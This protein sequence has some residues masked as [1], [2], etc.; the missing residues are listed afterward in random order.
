MALIKL[1]E[2]DGGQGWCIRVTAEFD[3]EELLGALSGYIANLTR[4]M[5]DSWDDSDPT[6]A[7]D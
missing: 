2:P 5:A 3:D 1:N 6:R 4:R 7:D